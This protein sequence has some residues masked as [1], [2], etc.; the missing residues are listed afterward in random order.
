MVIIILYFF[1]IFF[2]SFTTLNTCFKLAEFVFFLLGVPTQIKIISEFF[3]ALF[4]SDVKINLFCLKFFFKISSR[5]GSNIGTIPLFN[6]SI[7][8]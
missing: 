4:K 2:K 5:P 6:K 8:F 3:T 1:I 7:F